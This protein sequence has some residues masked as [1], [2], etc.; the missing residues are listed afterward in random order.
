MA[1]TCPK[2]GSDSSVRYRSPRDFEGRTYRRHKCRECGT[3]F[4][5]VQKVMSHAAAEALLDLMET[6]IESS[7]KT[8]ASSDTFVMLVLDSGNTTETMA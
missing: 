8:L 6:P 2:C 1:L 5:S 4:L 3:I 7:S